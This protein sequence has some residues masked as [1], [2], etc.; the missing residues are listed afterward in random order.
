GNGATA[1]VPIL[2]RSNAPSTQP[3]SGKPILVIYA[4][5]ADPSGYAASGW[6]GNTRAI[7]IDEKCSTNPHGGPTCMKITYDATDNFGR[8][9]W[10][11]PANDWGD[12]PGGKDLTGAHQLTFWAR[13]ESGGEKV[14]FKFGVLGPDKKFPDSSSGEITV[15]LTKEWKQY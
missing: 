10:Q 1:N 3:A 7:R 9:V 11:N 8:I 15:T 5:G 14:E 6:M 4:D 12:Q 2:A 13:G